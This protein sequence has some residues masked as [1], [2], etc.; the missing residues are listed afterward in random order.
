MMMYMHQLQ[1]TQIYL[2]YDLRREVDK[3]RALSGQSLAEYTRKA[4]ERSLLREKNARV[5]LEKLA[6][7]FI[8]S[9]QKSDKEVQEWLDWV[10]EERRLSDEVREE[11]LQKA[12]KRE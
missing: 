8:G 7:Q 12:L 2:P 6:D 5:N 3:A 9:S 1:R 4:L 10:R 11:R